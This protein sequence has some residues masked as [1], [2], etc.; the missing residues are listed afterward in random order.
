MAPEDIDVVELARWQ[1][2]VDTHLGRLRERMADVERKLD[3]LPGVI[4]GRVE[5]L[6]NG[7]KRANPSNIT[8]KDLSR[9]ILIPLLL[10]INVIILGLIVAIVFRGGI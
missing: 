8:W 7:S 6:F 9:S 10:G 2:V 4:E 3:D 5:K 1:G